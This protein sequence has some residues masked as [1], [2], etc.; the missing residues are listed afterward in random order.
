MRCFA[1]GVRP[2]CYTCFAML[3]SEDWRELYRTNDLSQA[4]AVATAV[5]AMEF[6]V[7]LRA[8]GRDLSTDDADS[9]GNPPYVVDVRSEDLDQLRPVLDQII[10]EQREFDERLAAKSKRKLRHQRIVLALVLLGSATGG[11]GALI[12][13]LL[14]RLH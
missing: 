1:R 13:A 12:A 10:D 14:R 5:G 6:D 9:P 11:L 4:R 2:R 8:V 7:Q 3:Q